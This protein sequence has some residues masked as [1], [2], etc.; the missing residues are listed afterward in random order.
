MHLISNAYQRVHFKK[1]HFVINI[2]SPNQ[3]YY[4]NKIQNSIRKRAI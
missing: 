1:L 2:K 4:L 3:R